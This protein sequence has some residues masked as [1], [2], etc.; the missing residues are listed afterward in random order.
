LT[1]SKRFAKVA[2][3]QPETDMFTASE[4]GKKGGQA[5]S[6]AKAAAARKNASKPRGKW[7]TA[8]AYEITNVPAFKAFGCVITKGSP[9]S[10]P[11]ASHEWIV[12]KVRAH[13][14][15]LDGIDHFEFA[16]LSANSLKV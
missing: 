7:V 2:A 10:N 3:Q 14:V 8:I 12:G 9:P 1:L 13:G 15:G 16:E 11:K 5:K 4:M 6:E